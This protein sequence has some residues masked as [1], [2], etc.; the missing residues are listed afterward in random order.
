MLHTLTPFTTVT[1]TSSSSAADPSAAAAASASA[2]GAAPDDPDRASAGGRRGVGGALAAAAAAS[3]A[4]GGGVNAGVGA[5]ASASPYAKLVVTGLSWSC[6]GQTI[7]ASYGRYDVSGWCTD[8]GALVT[9]NLGREA[10]APHKPDVTVDVDVCLMACSFHP[11]HPVSVCARGAEGCG[12]GAAGAAGGG[13]WWPVAAAGCQPGE[14]RAQSSGV[15]P[16]TFGGRA[17]AGGG[18]HVQRRRVRVGPEPERRGRH[19]AG[20]VQPPLR[21]QAPGELFSGAKARGGATRASSSGWR[22]RRQACV[23]HF[24]MADRMSVWRPVPHVPHSPAKD[25]HSQ[26]V[27]SCSA[28]TSAGAHLQHR[29][30][31]QHD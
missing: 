14:H 22:R 13:C 18:R 29:V 1:A 24:G 3:A 17:G 9:W 10:V 11:E 20:A 7:A 26:S 28:P 21:H 16:A 2:G 5:G 23:Q 25:R 4:G 30:A 15:A 6:T 19:A 31:V 12:R 27:A 8:R